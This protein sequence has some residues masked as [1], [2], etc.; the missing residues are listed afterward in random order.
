LADEILVDARGQR[1]PTPT[2]RLA[3]ALRGAAAGDLVRLLA[4]DPMAPVDVPH[5]TAEAGAE[6]VALT[7]DGPVLSILVRKG[8][9]LEQDA[10]R[11]G[12][13]APPGGL[14]SS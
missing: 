8:P 3:K 4:D 2:L 5:F 11:R 9:S 1:C 6:I 14:V 10:A 7:S 13:D 12:S